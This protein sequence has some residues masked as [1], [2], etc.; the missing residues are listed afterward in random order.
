MLRQWQVGIQSAQA[1][2]IPLFPT[3]FLAAVSSTRNARGWRT[4]RRSQAAFTGCGRGG[5]KRLRSWEG[6]RRWLQVRNIG[7]VNAEAG[8]KIAKD[9]ACRKLSKDRPM[10][11]YST[12]ELDELASAREIKVPPPWRGRNMA[13][14]YLD[15]LP[16]LSFP[17]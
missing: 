15:D 14:L 17:M 12:L 8:F 4:R 6:L 2:F 11:I 13:L 1:L 5:G 16:S 7:Q 3:G 10:D 9:R